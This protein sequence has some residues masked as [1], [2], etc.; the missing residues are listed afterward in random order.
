M[1]RIIRYLLT[2]IHL[3]PIQVYFRIFYSIKK[4]IIPKYYNITNT[5]VTGKSEYKITF[6]ES[7]ASIESYDLNNQAFTF[8]N[9][10][11]YFNNS[12]QWN[13]IEEGKLWNYN[14][15]YFDYLNQNTLPNSV[16]F[17][18]LITYIQNINI[19]KYGTEPYPTSLRIINWIKA[20]CKHQI[21][22]NIIDESLYKQLFFLSNNIEYHLLGN[23]LLENAFA[24]LFGS[25]YFRND[26]LYD[27]AKKLLLKQLDQQLLQDGAHFELSP[28]YHCII[29][30][31]LLDSI[32]IVKHN[33]WK[34]HELLPFLTEKASI[35]L[36]YINNMSYDDGTV[37]HLND[38]TI[39]IAPSIRKLL[40]Y[41]ESLQVRQKTGIA[42]ITYPKRVEAE[43]ECIVDVNE[44][45]PD[46][47]PGHA[48]A[49]TFT[50]ELRLRGRPFIVDTGISTYEISKRRDYEYR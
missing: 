22:N 37:A 41:A 40:E 30:F 15:H 13:Y 3:K 10:T 4:R 28:M 49:D 23:H 21:K 9:S 11:V 39:G 2:I 32:N 25:Y 24:L 36:N 6:L 26:K 48:H 42:I 34:K 8:L 43:Y 7:I 47:I 20:I 17:H 45:G 18:L 44:I 33:T 35:M 14:L 50:F 31:R 27:K 1:Y 16:I 38:S 12:I 46:Y 5:S 29:I 19:I